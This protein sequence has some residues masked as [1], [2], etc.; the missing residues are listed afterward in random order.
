MK[1]EKEK[2]LKDRE[3]LRRKTQNVIEKI[4]QKRRKEIE[5]RSDPKSK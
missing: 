5:R 4:K 3:F 1:N 2:R